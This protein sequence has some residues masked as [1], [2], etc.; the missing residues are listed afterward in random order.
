MNVKN[1]YLFIGLLLSIVASTAMAEPYF[2]N[3]YVKNY[4]HCS[5]KLLDD[6]SVEVY[7]RAHLA[8]NMS[9]KRRTDTGE[10]IYE[11]GETN[12]SIHTKHLREWAR[13]INQPNTE[14]IAL[15][16]KGALVSLYFYLPDGTPDLTIKPQDIS[17]I[18]LN[19]TSPLNLSNSVRGIKFKTNNIVNYAVSFTIL[20]NMLK[21]IRIGATVGGILTANKEEYPLLSSKGVSFNSLGNRCELFDPQLGIAPQALRVDPKFRLISETWQLKSVDLDHL[22]ESMANG[23]SVQAP[24]VSPI[25]SRFCLHYRALG[26]SG[27]RYMIKASNL[28]GL[29]G[30]NQYFQLREKAGHHAINYKVRMKHIENSESDFDLPKDQKF[31]QLSNNNNNMEQMCWSPKIRLYN[32]DTNI[33]EGHYSDTLNFTITPEA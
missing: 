25:A 31:I 9:Y 7:F 1:K 24:L 26:V 18:S 22:L 33:D 16:H 15:K 2:Y 10:Y 8:N 20:P 12:H 27:Y 29:A 6:N 32:T 21:S 17:N 14:I 30:N 23:Q 5:I 13:I 11:S 4:T 19:G 28:N 3:N